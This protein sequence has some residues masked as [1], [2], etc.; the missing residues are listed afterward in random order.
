MDCVEENGEYHVSIALSGGFGNDSYTVYNDV[1]DVLTS[2][3]SAD[4]TYLAGPYDEGVAVSFTVEGNDDD[5]CSVVTDTVDP[6]VCVT[7]PE[8]CENP[9]VSLSVVDA[10]GG[11]MDCVEE[12]GEYHVSIALSD[13]SGN[14]SYT[15]YNDAGDVLIANLSADG[16]YLAGPY[17]HAAAPTFTV[18]RTLHDALP[19]F[20]DTVDPDV[21]VTEPEPCENPTV[22][23]SVVDANGDAMDCVEED[24]EYHVS[25][26]LS[27]GSGNNSYTV[28][29][30][31][32]DVL[33]SNLSADGTYL[34]VP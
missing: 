31:S 4:G 10:N 14:D 11:A 24:G 16:T 33:T 7:E 23:L 8:P 6:D 20:T 25:I 32:G 27:G 1:G 12:D 13:G 26:A 29:D 9:T 22:S 34:A 28:Y 3:L 18:A 19:I 21:C 15:D 30:D 5:E 17:D 2:N